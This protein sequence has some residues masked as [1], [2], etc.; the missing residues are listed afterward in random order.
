MCRCHL[1]VLA[2][3]GGALGAQSVTGGVALGLSASGPRAGGHAGLNLGF[4][5]TPRQELRLHYSRQLVLGETN[6]SWTTNE[7]DVQMFALD[8]LGRFSGP[9]RG[10]YAVL[11]ASLSQISN[12]T[13]HGSHVTSSPLPG[14]G[15]YWG[16]G[17]G[18]TTRN[19]SLGLRAGL[20][21]SFGPR[22]ALE[23]DLNPVSGLTWVQAGAVWRFSL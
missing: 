16:P 14:G 20:G 18:T 13:A 23:V 9:D 15:I 10:G 19:G 7:Y 17:R 12:S 3:S 4:V 11:G 1:L 8:W 5:L 21:Y 6:S 2:L 22:F